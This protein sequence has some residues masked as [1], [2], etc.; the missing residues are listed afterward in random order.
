MFCRIMT[1]WS[2]QLIRA[3]HTQ[4][5]QADQR[6]PHSRPTSGSST[7]SGRSSGRAPYRPFE[8]YS[9]GAALAAPYA[10]EHSRNASAASRLG[11]V[12]ATNSSSND[13][14]PASLHANP[15]GRSSESDAIWRRI[16]DAIA[17]NMDKLSQIFFKMDI[18]CSGSVSRDEFELGL[19]HIGVFLTPREYER[20]YDSLATD[21]KVVASSG[22]AHGKTLSIRYADFLALFHGKSPLVLPSTSKQTSP[23]VAGVGNAR[24]WD[25]LVQSIDKL[26]PLFQQ[27]ERINQR[28]VSPDTFRDCLA[29]CGLALSNADYAA[30]RVR[31]LPF[32]YVRAV[33][34]DGS[35]AILSLSFSHACAYLCPLLLFAITIVF[36]ALAALVG[37]RQA[38]PSAWCRSCRRS[39]LATTAR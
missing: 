34:G 39:K 31:L 12:H 2:L 15:S 33:V 30:L 25:F 26:Q 28:Y 37:T 24:L 18:T 29:R 6:L 16:S 32:T 22:D 20:V 7:G 19:S 3:R 35:F 11:S 36:V 14:I 5:Q 23:P 9:A 8:Q 4:Q 17:H 27:L 21:L 38:E 1:E 13:G 10:T